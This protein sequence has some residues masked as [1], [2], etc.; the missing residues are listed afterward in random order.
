M[1]TNINEDKAEFEG[2]DPTI[3][4]P[5]SFL[6]TMFRKNADEYRFLT[7]EEQGYKPGDKKHCRRC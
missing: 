3:L 5:G 7:D 4:S 2:I 6:R 1:V